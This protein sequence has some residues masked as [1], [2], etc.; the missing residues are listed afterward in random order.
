MSEDDAADYRQQAGEEA[1]QAFLE[2]RATMG[3]P[4]APEPCGECEGEGFTAE[5]FPPSEC[6]RCLGTGVQP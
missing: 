5:T 6:P 2:R 4:E 3:G 1:W